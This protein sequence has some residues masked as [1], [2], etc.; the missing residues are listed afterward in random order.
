[1]C[2]KCTLKEI[3]AFKI[4]KYHLLKQKDEKRVD[5]LKWRQ[6][7]RQITIQRMA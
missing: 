4:S 1:M 7:H 3:N 2:K 6:R 5:F